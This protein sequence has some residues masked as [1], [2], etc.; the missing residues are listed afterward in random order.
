MEALRPDAV[1]V[2]LSYEAVDGLVFW[3]G[4]W[5]TRS[6]SI[7]QSPRMVATL[8]RALRPIDDPDGFA[9]LVAPAY[10]GFA[11]FMAERLPKTRILLHRARFAL[12]YRARF[13]QILPFPEQRQATSRRYNALAEGIEALFLKAVPKAE[14]FDLGQ[15]LPVAELWHRWGLHPI[16]YE[17][18][19]Y[20]RFLS[21]FRR[22]FGQQAGWG[23]VADGGLDRLSETRRRWKAGVKPVSD[24]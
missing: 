4:G 23:A 12:H 11:A 14:P 22:T 15:D 9:A 1:L 21:L 17:E 20:R 24:A 18:A 6:V 2:D 7:R 5:I 16:H 8:P 19:Y 13:G 3:N 10:A